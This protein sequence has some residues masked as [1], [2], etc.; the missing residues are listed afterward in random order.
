[1][2]EENVESMRGALDAFANRDVDG[3]VRFADPEIQFEP[4]LA[5]VEGNYSGHGGVREFMADA[6]E[7]E[8]LRTDLRDIRDLG[9]RVLALGAFHARGRESGVEVEAPFAILTT[10]RDGLIVSLKDYGEKAPALEAA[11]LTE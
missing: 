7:L 4:I 1:M 11:G 8:I 10:F 9:D 6:L 5:M 2:S 3:L